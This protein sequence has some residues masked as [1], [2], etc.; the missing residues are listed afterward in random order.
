MTT[1]YNTAKITFFRSPITSAVHTPSGY[2]TIDDV[3]KLI[4]SPQYEIATKHLRNLTDEKEQRKFKAKA[5]DYVCFGG[6]FNDFR[7]EGL[8]EPSMLMCIDLDHIVNV[9]EL[10]QKLIEDVYFDTHLIFRSPRGNGLKWV[11]NIE[12]EFLQVG[13]KNTYLAIRQYLINTYNLSDEQVDK[14]CSNISRATF[15]CYDP[16]VYFLNNFIKK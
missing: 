12:D 6:R 7:D 9:D 10:K 13:F 11:I 1:Q 8:I 2:L 15:L 5:L 16:E 3:A 4:A 14:A